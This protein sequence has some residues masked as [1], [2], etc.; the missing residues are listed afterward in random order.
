MRCSG[1]IGGETQVRGTKWKLI[2]W[3]KHWEQGRDNKADAGLVCSKSGAG[4][5]E[6]E[7]EHTHRN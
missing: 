2:G 1:E 4:N 5:Q 7:G 3:K 6:S